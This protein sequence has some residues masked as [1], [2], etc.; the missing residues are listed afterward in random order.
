MCNKEE[1]K[2]SVLVNPKSYST[3]VCTTR[4]IRCHLSR[5]PSLYSN[6]SRERGETRTVT[7]DLLFIPQ[8]SYNVEKGSI[9]QG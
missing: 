7:P 1:V 6:Q 2:A 4:F 9:H 3:R 8:A 5:R